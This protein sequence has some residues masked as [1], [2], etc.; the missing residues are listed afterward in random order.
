[1]RLVEIWLLRVGMG[2]V[3]RVERLL[4]RRILTLEFVVEQVDFDVFLRE[5]RVALEKLLGI[6]S[7]IV[8]EEMEEGVETMIVR[9]LEELGRLESL[10]TFENLFEGLFADV[11]GNILDF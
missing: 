6:E 2:L 1:M 5:R 11:L 9:I 8:R 4:Q 7:S 3:R 10:E